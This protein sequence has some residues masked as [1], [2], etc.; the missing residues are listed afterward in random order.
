LT[1]LLALFLLGTF[2]DTFAVFFLQLL[3]V[4]AAVVWAGR[5]YVVAR[6]RIKKGITSACSGAQTAA[7]TFLTAQPSA[8]RFRFCSR[9]YAEQFAAA[10][11]GGYLTTLY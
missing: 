11:P 9:T 6:A 8:W 10:N 3:V 2:T 4:F 5:T 7:V 1:I